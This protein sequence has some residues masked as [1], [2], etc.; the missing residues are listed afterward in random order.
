MEDGA[1]LHNAPADKVKI[2]CLKNVLIVF[3]VFVF[4]HTTHR[5]AMTAIM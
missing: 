2:A 5:D 4:A 3:F 1:T